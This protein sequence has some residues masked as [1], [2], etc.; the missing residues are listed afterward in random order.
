[1]CA[2]A[3]FQARKGLDALHFLTDTGEL[4]GVPRE[5]ATYPRAEGYEALGN[6]RPVPLEDDEDEQYLPRRSTDRPLRPT[7]GRGGRFCVMALCELPC[8]RGGAP[9]DRPE[10]GSNH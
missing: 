3:F 4:P 9:Q 2:T 6:C 8:A 1:M 5:G 10:K 7:V